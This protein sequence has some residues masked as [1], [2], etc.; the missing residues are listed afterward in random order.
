MTYN[1]RWQDIIH[2]CR[3]GFQKKRWDLRNVAGPLRNV[4]SIVFRAN[5]WNLLFQDFS[6]VFLGISFVYWKAISGGHS[7]WA[8]ELKFV[9]VL[10]DILNHGK[11]HRANSESRLIILFMWPLLWLLTSSCPFGLAMPAEQ[12]TV[13]TTNN[14]KDQ[15]MST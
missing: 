13:L 8:G 15:C 14:V 7:R 5:N 6:F 4:K 9:L 11:N 10:S 1:A 12:D 3:F 2:L